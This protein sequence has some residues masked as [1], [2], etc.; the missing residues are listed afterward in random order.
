MKCCPVEDELDTG[1]G[2]NAAV[3]TSGSAAAGVDARN[4]VGVTGDYGMTTLSGAQRDMHV[5]HVVV[6][7]FCA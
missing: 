2:L 1:S 5:D 3:A 7:A 6:A 4:V